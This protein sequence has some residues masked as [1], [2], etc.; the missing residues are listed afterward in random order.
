MR[1]WT[2]VFRNVMRRKLRSS[3]T[4]F[5]V[6]IAVGSV[7]SLVGIATGF[8]D[9]F[10]TLYD[11][12]QVDLMVTRTGSQ[13]KLTSTLDET[14]N[15]QIDA[16]P[17]VSETIPGLIDI[18]S[19]PDLDLFVVPV[20]GLVPGKRA[21]K[22]FNIQDGE[23]IQDSEEP[24]VILGSILAGTLGKKVGDTLEVV[25]EEPFTVVGVFDSE[26]GYEN[27]SIVMSLKQLQRVMGREGQMTGTSIVVDDTVDEERL[28]EI[29]AE[30]KGMEQGISV[31]KPR[32]QVENMTEIQIAIAMA[33][34]T[35]TVAILIGSLGTL[36]TMFM[37]IQER[38]QELGIL[39]AIG[40][41]GR[42]IISMILGES[43][44][45][46]AAGGVV[47]AASA[48]LLVK[49]LTNLPATNGLIQG[50]VS[51][52]V[53]AQ[54][55]LAAVVVGLLGGLIPAYAASKMEPTAALKQ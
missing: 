38:T 6:A 55:C 46:S 47:G 45:L 54:A 41:E 14:L 10:L 18:V 52:S 23:T 37:S 29:A 42:M 13:R 8:K 16:I 27:G 53:L 40:W 32:E 31:R 19:F 35:S 15:D 50:D 1:F 24:N 17:G 22:A 30:V 5:S 44:M 49:L 36:N 2:L 3:L 21:M 20:S 7:V 39:K 43:I 12:Y 48:T 51:V 28:Q 25:E 4:I 33:W 11:S 9:A 26:H 34:L